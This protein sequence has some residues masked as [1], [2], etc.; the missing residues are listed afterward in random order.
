MSLGS[1][2]STHRRRNLAYGAAVRAALKSAKRSLKRGNC[3]AANSSLMS[4]S[5]D[6]GLAFGHDISRGQKKAK[7]FFSTANG[8]AIAAVKKSFNKHC[9]VSKKKG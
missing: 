4:A 7:R 2:L 9:K 8:K 3:A 1:S 5:M 6:A